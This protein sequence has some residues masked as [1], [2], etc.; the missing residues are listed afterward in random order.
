LTIG[1]LATLGAGSM[2]LAY[3]EE[4]GK[5][6]FQPVEEVFVNED[7][8]LTYLSI[9]DTE[10]LRYEMVIIGQPQSPSTKGKNG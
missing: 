5:N 7:P 10:S 4:T 2:V 6:E 1:A 8:E 3:N 9:Q